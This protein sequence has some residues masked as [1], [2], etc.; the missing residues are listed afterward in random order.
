VTLLDVFFTFLSLFFLHGHQFKEG[1]LD[2]ILFLFLK[3]TILDLLLLLFKFEFDLA[4]DVQIVHPLVNLLCLCVDR[5]AHGFRERLFTLTGGLLVL[6]S[7]V[8]NWRLI[9]RGAV[10]LTVL[11]D[12]A[13]GGFYIDCFKVVGNGSG[14]GSVERFDRG[15]GHGV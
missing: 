8:L 10:I 13:C 1:I 7:V 11:T 5:E 3:H 2:T 12:R 6:S 9:S 14:G 4:S 15:E